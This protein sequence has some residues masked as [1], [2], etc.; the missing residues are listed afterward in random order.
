MKTTMKKNTRKVI[1]FVI[2]LM[3]ASLP[4]LEAKEEE[5]LFHQVEMKGTG[6]PDGTTSTITSPDKKTL[7]LLFDEFLAEVPQYDGNNDNDEGDSSPGARFNVKRS[8]K[9]CKINISAKIPKGQKV[10][11]VEISVDFR[12]ATSVESGSTAMFKSVL[13]NWE[14]TGRRQGRNKVVIAQKRWSRPIDEDWI[15]SKTRHLKTNSGCSING[16][17]EINL[18]LRN[19]ISAAMGRRIDPETTSALIALDSADLAGKLKIKINTSSCETGEGGDED[20][21]SDAVKCRRGWEYNPILDRCIRSHSR[22]G[23]RRFSSFRNRY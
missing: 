11:S 17:K 4:S 19:I 20:R 21:N 16:D 15:I 10:S 14:G 7:T 1:T 13:M 18:K 8:H 3:V 23:G 12:G 2:V 6:C 5:I 9:I 22:R